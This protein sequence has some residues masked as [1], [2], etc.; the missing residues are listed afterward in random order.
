M[1]S[2]FAVLH[3]AYNLMVAGVHAAPSS[4]AAAGTVYSM[5]SGNGK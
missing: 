5:A 3:L 4:L 2:L 1:I